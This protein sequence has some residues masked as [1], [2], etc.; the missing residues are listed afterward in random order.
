MNLLALQT[1][2]PQN[3]FTQNDCW[4]ILARSPARER[5]RDRSMGL[6]QKV[7]TRP[8]G[9]DRRHFA[10]ESIEDVF[11]LP[12]DRLH[13]EFARNAPALAGEAL[14][15]ALEDCEI[16]PAELDALLICTCTGYLCPGLTSY[17][18]EQQGLRSD[19][20]LQDLV[21]LG[22]GAAVPTLRAAQA[23]LAGNPEAKVATIAVEICSAAFY[24]DDDPGVLI[25]ACL[26]SDGAAAA[27][28]SGKN[29]KTKDVGQW[30]AKGFDTLHIPANRELLRFEQK[31]G[32]LRNKLHRSV[33]EKAAEAVKNLWQ[34]STQPEAHFLVHPG[35]RDV[36]DAVRKVLP[37]E[38]ALKESRKVLAEHGNMSSPSILFALKEFIDNKTVHGKELWLT[39][40]GA[41]FSGH[42]FSLKP[43]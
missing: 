8:H 42:S 9:I 38:P 16:A 1:A 15:K 11:T 39:S 21:G 32:F 23:I 43:C 33:P 13:E 36:L 19:A 5:L 22:C 4:E 20:F 18:A 24:L 28:W 7:L 40:F 35:G 30:E 37:G 3:T 10:I 41:G 26:F 12:L 17:V 27:I 14:A 2:V 34:K 31:D 29:K 6:L 25:S